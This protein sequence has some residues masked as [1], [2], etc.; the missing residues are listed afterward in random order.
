METSHYTG[1]SKGISTSNT[2]MI[3]SQTPSPRVRERYT[4]ADKDGG[5]R[6]LTVLAQLHQ[7]LDEPC[8]FRN[9]SDDRQ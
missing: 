5:N 6:L 9:I 1:A 8:R 4:A 2:L 3:P 7:A